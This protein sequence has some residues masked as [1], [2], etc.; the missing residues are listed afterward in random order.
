MEAQGQNLYAVRT[1]CKGLNRHTVNL[2]GT[3]IIFL[4]LL[5]WICLPSQAFPDSLKQ[6][7]EPEVSLKP[8]CIP[9]GGLSLVRII[10]ADGTTIRGVKFSGKAIP[11]FRNRTDRGYLALVGADLKM[12]P[13]DKVVSV[14]WNGRKGQPSVTAVRLN[15]FYKKFPEEHLHLPKKMVEFPPKILKRVLADQH[16]IRAACGKTSSHVYWQRPFLWPVPPKIMSPFGLRRFFNG[17]PRSPHSGVDLR[18]RIGTPVR[19]TNNG[20]VAL[21][22]NCYLSGKTIVIDH[23]EGLF[24]LYAHLSTLMVRPGQEV[25]R[26]MV[27]G[28]AGATGRA[29]GPHLHWGI[30]LQGK[31]LDP[32]ELMRVLGNRG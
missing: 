3:L 19:A 16:A 13:G 18:A 26:G 21:V 10:P 8:A 17:E 23:G 14:I 28:K 27:I 30:S 4:C 32:A 6:G 11:F 9:P 7:L 5:A 25:K 22:R 15:V 31:R 12:T 2:A 20:R 1:L 29:T 24:S